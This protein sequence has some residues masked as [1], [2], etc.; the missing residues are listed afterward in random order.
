MGS[1]LLMSYNS[2]GLWSGWPYQVE[3][4]KAETKK[5][6]CDSLRR[7]TMSNARSGKLFVLSI[8]AVLLVVSS[9]IISCGGGQV[10]TPTTS[11]TTGTITTSLSDPPTCTN[12]DH[13]WVTVTKVTANISSTAGPTDSGWVTL[14]DL[15]SAPRQLDL[16]SLVSTTCLLT[17]LGS[18]SGLPP[19]DYQQIRIYLLANNAANGP[20][21]NNCGSNGFNCVV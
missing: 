12:F 3:G 18:T 10:S 5:C 8:L 13:V 17:Q 7:I 11:A 6:P 21:P 4:E 19:G 16:L 14:V 9:W 15:T 1:C 2:F 20:S